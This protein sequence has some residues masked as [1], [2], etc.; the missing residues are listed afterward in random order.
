[1]ESGVDFVNSLEYDMSLKILMCLEDPSDIVRASSVSRSWRHF[2]IANGLCKHLCLSMFPQLSRVDH[3]TE[4]SNSIRRPSDAGTSNFIEWETLERE[5]RVYAFL[6]RGCTSFPVRECIAEAIV[7][8]STDNYPEESIHHTLEPRDR[9][10]DRASYWSS[11][12]QNNPEVPETLLYKLV[13]D[14]CVISEINIKPFQAFFQ[15]GFPIYSAKSVRFRMG[16]SKSTM[17]DSINEL[18]QSSIDEKLVWT[19]I[20]PEFPMS[21]EN[22]LQKFKLPEPVLCIGGY[23]QIDLLGRVQRQ[24]ID[25]LFYICVSHVKVIGRSLSGAF[26]IEII[27]PSQKFVMKALSYAIPSLPEEDPNEMSR[28]YWQRHVRDLGHFVNLLRGNV[29]D[30]DAAADGWDEDEDGE[31]DED[32]EEDDYELDEN[33]DGEF[34]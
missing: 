2:V 4:F 10:G 22:C 21:H 11:K 33:M 29:M 23:L 18:G 26:G 12:G 9:I 24:E 13:S 30:M 3:V 1:M 27:E 25:C 31:E 19:Y 32:E 8:S 16:H 5:H 6:A 34:V 15:Q 17:N 14:L 28:M 20:S 7:A